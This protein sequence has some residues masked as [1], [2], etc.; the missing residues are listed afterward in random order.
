VSVREIPIRQKILL[1]VPTNG[2]PDEG[3]TAIIEALVRGGITPPQFGG[4]C[5]CIT[6]RDDRLRFRVF[7]DFEWVWKTTRGTLPKRLRAHLV[8]AGLT[9]PDDIISTVGTIASAHAEKSIQHLMDFTDEFDWRPGDFGDAGSCYWG[10]NASAR[11]MLVD[12]NALAVRFYKLG[13]ETRGIARA[14]MV[15]IGGDRHVIFN[16]YPKDGDTP[17]NVLSIARI[18]AFYLGL[19]YRK[20]TSLENNGSTGG[21]LYINCPGCV[22]GPPDDLPDSWGFECESIETYCCHWCNC[23]LDE[24][25]HEHSPDGD[26]CCERCY[27]DRVAWCERC[28][29][30]CW[31]D[32]S[33]SVGGRR[34][35]DS[36]VEQYA[37]LC[38][39]CEE[40]CPDED[41]VEVGSQNWCRYCAENEAVCCERCD[42]RF[43]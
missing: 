31:G 40:Y 25:D 15:P 11:E 3:V 28:E 29:T 20:L 2:I 22:V 19:S 16:A 1:N 23:A 38:P 8:K 12:M 35:C 36:C 24:E 18:V 14:W 39:C 37:T 41:C 9:V 6:C 26:D 43:H 32:D 10:S 21:A 7:E 17:Y 4:T 42:K 27:E 34:W 13:D 30:A 5:T 33:S